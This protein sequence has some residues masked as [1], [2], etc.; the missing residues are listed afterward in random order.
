MKLKVFQCNCDGRNESIVATTSKKKAAELMRISMH[1]A[2]LYMS[3]TTKPETCVVALSEPG[4]VFV[5]PSRTIYSGKPEWARKGGG[6]W[7][8]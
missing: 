2:N 3:I 6:L 1:S 8:S 5:A 7:N 4:V